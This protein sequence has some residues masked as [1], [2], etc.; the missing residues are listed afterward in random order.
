MWCE[1]FV[2]AYRGTPV[3]RLSVHYGRASMLL[4]TAGDDRWTEPVSGAR[5]IAA[6]LAELGPAVNGWPVVACQRTRSD[7]LIVAMAR[8]ADG[9]DRQILVVHRS[10]A[11]VSGAVVCN[12]F[13]YTPGGHVTDAARQPFRACFE[14]WAGSLDRTAL[15]R[16][17]A[18]LHAGL[19]VAREYYASTDSRSRWRQYDPEARFSCT[20]QGAGGA[21][22]HVGPR[23]IR[24]RYTQLALDYGRMSSRA[25]ETC[26]SVAPAAV[27]AMVVATVPEAMGVD[28]RV[29]REIVQ[30]F[31]ID[32]RTGKILNDLLFIEDACCAGGGGGHAASRKSPWWSSPAVT[33]NGHPSSPQST[34]CGHARRTWPR[35]SISSSSSS[36]S[37][38][39]TD[40]GSPSTSAVDA[41]CSTSDYDS[42]DDH[43]S[44]DEPGPGELAEL[45]TRLTANG[46]KIRR[47]SGSDA[48]VQPSQ[49]SGGLNPRQLFIGCVPLHVKYGQLKLLFEQFGEVTYVKVY[50]SY[51][52]QTGAKMM[53]NYAFLFFKN[54]VS[55]DRAIAASPVPLDANWKLNVSRPLRHTTPTAGER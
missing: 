9:R 28:A 29:R 8:A 19:S 43:G 25:V 47:R 40:G 48:D 54:E 31:V 13:F 1:R 4:E 42:G 44:N 23:A 35:R 51:S 14:R 36:S 26:W 37:L 53:H 34:A 12:H 10:A 2:S 33:T 24:K 39:T 38:T 17:R 49:P 16:H 41:G 45:R 11:A 30:F 3:D 55:V 20:R 32:A 7:G 27:A 22:V 21:D 50:E 18:A 6:R 15:R 52:K 5:D 46:L